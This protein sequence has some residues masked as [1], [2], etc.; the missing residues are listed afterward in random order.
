MRLV[1]P[2]TQTSFTLRL[3]A[4]RHWPAWLAIGLLRLATP[5]PYA[6][7]LTIGAWLGRRLFNL[8][9]RRRQLTRYNL[10]Q[11][12][13]ELDETQREQ[14]ARQ[15]FE[16]LGI[17]LLEIAQCWWGNAARLRARVRIEG[18]EHLQAA[19]AQGRGAVLLSAHT[20]T[21]EIGGRLLGLFTPFH[22]MYRP[23]NSPVLEWII[24]RRRRAHFE[25]VIP[26]DDVRQL[27]KSLKDNKP[28]WYAPDQGFTG[29]NHVIAPFFGV[30]APTNPA[31]SRI[32][33][34]SGAPVLPFLVERLPEK[35]GYLLRISAPLENFPGADLAED[36]ARVNAMIE[37]Q[38]RCAPEQYL[39]MHNRF[40]TRDYRQLD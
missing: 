11:C 12:F 4:P 9:R 35:Q 34:A 19:L 32:A 14:L 3:L 25:G 27:L 31:T 15:H 16:S 22:L 36:A 23:N 18:L 2:R 29:K 37:E 20:T 5:L 17:G 38:V 26:R 8:T 33:K 28:V 40:K 13:P 21:L 30:P 6:W 1:T 39:W 10:A 7:Q 24:S